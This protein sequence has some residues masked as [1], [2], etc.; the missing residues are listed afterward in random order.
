MQQLKNPLQMLKF[1]SGGWT[2]KNGQTNSGKTSQAY[3][4]DVKT[5]LQFE[6]KKMEIDEDSSKTFGEKFKKGRASKSEKLLASSPPLLEKGLHVVFKKHFQQSLAATVSMLRAETKED[7]SGLSWQSQV[8]HDS[9]EAERQATGSHS[10]AVLVASPCHGMASLAPAYSGDLRSSLFYTTTEV[11]PTAKLGGTTCQCKT[12]R[13]LHIGGLS[14]AFSALPGTKLGSIV[15]DGQTPTRQAALGAEIHHSVFFYGFR[16]NGIVFLFVNTNFNH[17][18]I[19]EAKK[20]IK[21][22]LRYHVDETNIRLMSI[23]DGLEPHDSRTLDFP[24]LLRA[25]E[26]NMTLPLDKLIEEINEKE[27]QKVTCLIVDLSVHYLLDADKHYDIPRVAL[28]PGLTVTCALRYNSPALVS[29]NVLL[30]NG[31]N[32]AILDAL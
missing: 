26:N 31:V 3:G 16:E 29:S 9:S 2:P 23:P 4:P 10:L 28:Y 19:M 1:G 7:T 8:L 6:I 20:K 17:T 5:T 18:R 21:S 15:I 32:Q 12:S 22:T 30:S 11:A 24:K 25:L 27:E 13:I 14:G